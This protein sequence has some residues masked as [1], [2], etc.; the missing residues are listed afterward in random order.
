MASFNHPQMAEVGRVNPGLFRMGG[1]GSHPQNIVEF[2][3]NIMG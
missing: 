1:W 3:G 2:H